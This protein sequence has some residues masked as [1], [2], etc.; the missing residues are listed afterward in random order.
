MVVFPAKELEELAEAIMTLQ[1][2]RDRNDARVSD[3]TTELNVINEEIEKLG[4]E[5][6]SGE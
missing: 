5:H 1:Q 6:Q 3:Y 4:A 2:S